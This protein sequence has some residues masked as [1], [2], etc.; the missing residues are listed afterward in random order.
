[1]ERMIAERVSKVSAELDVFIA[2]HLQGL[3][4]NREVLQGEPAE[5]IVSYC[6]KHD[7]DLVVMPTRG[8]SPMRHFILGSVSAKVL[9]DI[10]CPVVTGIHL[11]REF[12]F[13]KFRVGRVLVAVDLGPRSITV[14]QW[15][16]EIAREFQGDLH[17][18]HVLPGGNSETHRSNGAAHISHAR[19][20]LEELLESVPSSTPIQSVIRSGEPHKEVAQAAGALRAD[21]VVIGRGTS[22]GVF[23]RLRA[24]SYGIV[25]EAP[26]PVLSV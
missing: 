25:R 17:V 12:G 10:G 7:T 15:G 11:D 14:L 2:E 16:A 24:Q 8:R 20:A 5:S 18:V 19:M 1:M 4:A 3:N 23:G 26:C 21:L 22:G 9:H 13:P 6:E